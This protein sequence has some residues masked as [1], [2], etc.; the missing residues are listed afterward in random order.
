MDATASFPFAIE[1]VPAARR[2]VGATLR[3]WACQDECIQTLALMVTELTTNAVRHAAS[4][5]DVAV[6]LR[7]DAVLRLAVTDWGSGTVE[8]RSGAGP[9][10]WGL[11]FV[12]RFAA[13]WGVSRTGGAKTVWLELVV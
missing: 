10:G 1:S 3:S 9:G 5:F 2:W 7:P 11:R 13:R 6:A 8:P 4:G 12:E